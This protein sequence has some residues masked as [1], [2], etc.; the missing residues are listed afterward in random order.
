VHLPH[1]FMGVREA[2]WTVINMKLI[3]HELQVNRLTA[4]V[5][6]L[7]L[8]YSVRIHE[9]MLILFVSFLEGYQRPVRN[10]INI[11]IFNIKK[12]Y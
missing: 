7:D 10:L 5:S 8:L 9:T 1:C 2:K 4:P 12:W 3:L 11:V 6:Y